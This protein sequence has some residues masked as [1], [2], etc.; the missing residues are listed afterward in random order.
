MVIS[1]TILTFLFRDCMDYTL[2]VGSL[3]KSYNIDCK[4]NFTLMIHNFK[5]P[6]A[7]TPWCFDCCF[8][9]FRKTISCLSIC[10]IC[11][12]FI[13]HKTIS[14]PHRLSEHSVLFILSISHNDATPW[15]PLKLPIYQNIILSILNIFVLIIIGFL[16]P[17]I[18]W[19]AHS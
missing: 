16:T 13:I 19:W 8:N 7:F 4:N 12:F 15:P 14:L 18:H 2:P 1:R 6:M 9:T 5:F 3:I 17:Q 10:S 11:S